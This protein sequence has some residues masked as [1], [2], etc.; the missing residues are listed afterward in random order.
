MQDDVED[1][2]RRMIK[3]GYSLPEK[4]CIVG[5]SYGGYAALM[6]SVKT[7]DLYQCAVSFAGVSDI[8]YLGPVHTN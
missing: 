1:G 3:Q 5:A 4:I 6:G 8:A 7:P 2:A